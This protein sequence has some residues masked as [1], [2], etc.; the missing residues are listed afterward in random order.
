MEHIFFWK[1]WS[2]AYKK[3]YLFLLGCFILSLINYSV[4]LYIGIDAVILWE[5]NTVLEPTVT[6]VNKF[7]L[8]LFNYAVEAES[9][10]IKQHFH[11]SDVNI[12]LFPSYV[13]GIFLSLALLVS[14]T[15][16]TYLRSFS[17]FLASALI[18][19]WIVTLNTELLEVYGMTNQTITLSVIIVFGSMSY[20]FKAFKTEISFTT[21]LCCFSGAGLIFM[22]IAGAGTKVPYPVL[23]LTNFGIAVP[24]ALSILF[25]AINGFEIINGLL[26]L[27]AG[28]RNVTQSK[29]RMFNFILISL[30]YLSNVL[31]VLL[32][33][34]LFIDWNIVYINVFILYI[35][36]ALL[37]IWGY[38][39]RAVLFK[40]LLPFYPF[41]GFVYLVLGIISNATIAYAFITGNDPMSECFEYA[42]VYSHL[43]FGT[44]FFLYVLI[45]F[46]P[47]FHKNISIYDVVYK[48]LN[49]PFFLV[50]TIGG[51]A[52]I[53][54]FSYSNYFAFYLGMAGYCNLA[55]DV[56]KLQ[57]DLL[58]AKQYYRTGVQYEF[59]N[60]RSSY[61][62][63]AIA[64]TEQNKEEQLQ[65]YTGTLVKH[66]T[67][68]S[69]ANLSNFYLKEEMFFQAMFVLRDGLDKFPESGYLANNL[70][71]LY[72][73]TN[74]VDSAFY[75][76]YYAKE[77]ITDPSVPASNILY[78]LTKKGLFS[79][80]DSTVLS[81]DY[82]ENKIFLSNKILLEMALGHGYN[83]PSFT[84]PFRDSLSAGDFALLYNYALSKI[85]TNDSSVSVQQLDSLAIRPANAAFSDGLL[86]LKA[87]KHYYSGNKKAAFAG[88]EQLKNI[89]AKPDVFHKLSATWQMEQKA[90]PPAV[91]NFEKIL[92]SG[93]MAAHLNYAIAVCENGD[94]LQSL[95]I[96]KELVKKG[97][98]EIN[99]S[100][101]TMLDILRVSDPDSVPIWTE[102]KRLQ[103]LYFR[104][105]LLNEKSLI[106]IFTSLQNEYYHLLAGAEIVQFFLNMN[107]L[108]TAEEIYLG[109]KQNSTGKRRQD[110]A[111]NIA[112][113]NLFLQKN[114]WQTFS[115]LAAES[116]LNPED[117]NR[118]CYYKARAAEGLNDR[119]L[120][121]KMYDRLL[122][123]A[124]YFE[125]GILH[126][127]EFYKNTDQAKAYEVITDAVQFYPQ[128][129]MLLK[130]Y[131]WYA[132]ENNLITYSDE[133]LE[134]LFS[135]VPE[136]EYKIFRED[137]LKKKTALEKSNETL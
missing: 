57:N 98:P 119:A 96:L 9:Y 45:N 132:L 71:I 37:G 126:A 22:L 94:H 109:L 35:V 46:S 84:N 99:A 118:R 66:P 59:Q 26:Y 129:A 25:I 31:L 47:V 73:K 111:V 95:A 93:G 33:K 128:S 125:E 123:E 44:I 81:W 105:D 106:E 67:E 50:R 63:A 18:M 62:L 87:M 124:P 79:M 8:H 27:T 90:F 86:F 116:Y 113:L 112:A 39:K 72:S 4:S 77:K 135:M 14:F 58:L 74:I 32:R 24:V 3:I 76:L 104:K 7:M 115:R 91:E 16:T 83:G 107:Q 23:Y 103:F 137:Y 5:K 80:A 17:Y 12:N 49:A 110:G 11:A 120:A 41:G 55:G 30:I 70:G 34:M 19:L 127:A 122:Y 2:K 136:K 6:I 43:C 82:S 114:D 68:F 51:I 36:S 102:D 21:R 85:K 48:P 56:Y 121:V 42:I 117:E 134:R 64:E 10:L 38:K 75:Y 69:Y 52:V 13:L 101:K 89:S 1:Q 92:S 54:L 28:S 15:I 65:Y 29:S 97:T 108:T 61:T 131:V 130:A 78:T 40:D 60:H 88:L 53:A 20:Y 100:A 133:A